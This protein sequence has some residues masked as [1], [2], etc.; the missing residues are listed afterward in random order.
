LFLESLQHQSACFI[1]LTY[2]EENLPSGG[3]L[4][5]AH[6]VSWLKRVRRATP[7]KL[8]YF[9][10]GEYGDQ[11]WRPHYHCLLFG[12]PFNASSEEVVKQTWGLGHISIGEVNQATIRYTCGYTLKKLTKAQNP[13]LDGRTPEFARMSRMPGIGHSIALEVAEQLLTE[14]GSKALLVDGDVPFSLKLGR[15]SLTLGRY[16][17]RVIREAIGMEDSWPDQA[18]E[19]YMEKLWELRQAAPPGTPLSELVQ[20]PQA[21]LNLIKRTEIFNSRRSL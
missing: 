11:T 3:N 1:T 19:A 16:L 21:A 5:P 9:L 12:L 20:Q 14:H 15:K 6:V 8:R 17:R 10:V 7:A 4:V 13:R 18:R 2:A